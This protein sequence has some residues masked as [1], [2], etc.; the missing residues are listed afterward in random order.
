[1]KYALIYR[2]IFDTFKQLVDVN[3]FL[4]YNDYIMVFVTVFL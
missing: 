3:I 4:K 2:E 1:M